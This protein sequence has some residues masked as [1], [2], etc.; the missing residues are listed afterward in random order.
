MIRTAVRAS[1]RV[2][3]VAVIAFAAMGLAGTAFADE[4]TTGG[5][6]LTTTTTTTTGLPQACTLLPEDLAQQTIKQRADL[7]LTST[8]GGAECLY[9]DADSSAAY[10]VD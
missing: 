3:A 7:V 5:G 4:D 6:D 9:K 2:S 8:S 1:V 10:A